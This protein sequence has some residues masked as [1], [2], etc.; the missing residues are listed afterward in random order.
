MARITPEQL[1][2]SGTEHGEQTA[3]F[4]WCAEN[5]A[6]YP[7]L[8]WFFAIP[9]GG[10]RG[11]DAKARAIRGG[12]LKAEGVKAGVAD[13]FLMCARGG[14]HGLFIEMKRPGKRSNTSAEQDEFGAYCHEN[15]YGFVVCD[16]WQ[17]ARD[18]LV[19][20]LSQKG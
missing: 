10:T 6:T 19:S 5:I 20:Y 1:A 3:L 4:C 9:N 2:K 7:E 15:N 17:S 11:D 12:A 16:T 8:R 14:W 18:M 13:T